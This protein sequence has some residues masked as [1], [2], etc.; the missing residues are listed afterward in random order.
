MPLQSGM[1]S[2]NP[3]IDDEKHDFVL[4]KQPST[5][6]CPVGLKHDFPA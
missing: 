1:E 2:P 5:L 4:I 6:G 3:N